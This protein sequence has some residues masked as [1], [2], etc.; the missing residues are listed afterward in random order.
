[1][2]LRACVALCALVLSWTLPAVAQEAEPTV[3][4]T[5]AAAEAY[6]RGSAFYLNEDFPRAARWFETAYRLAPGVP[7]LIQALRAQLRAGQS[8]RAAN[9]ALRLRG[10]HADDEEASVYADEIIARFEPEL[11]RL[12]I[13]CECQLEIDGRV[14]SYREAMLEPAL[15]HAV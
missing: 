3:P 5:A 6:D 13:D 8:I 1:M 2:R 9:L 12:V 15:A 4:N 7:A 14:W 11:V 10:L